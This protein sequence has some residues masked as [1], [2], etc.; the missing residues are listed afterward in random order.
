VPE[1]SRSPAGPLFFVENLNA[2]TLLIRILTLFLALFLT[3]L[4]EEAPVVNFSPAQDVC[5]E[6]VDDV[7]EEAI[8]QVVP[9]SH[10]KIQICSNPLWA[11]FDQPLW[12]G[13]SCHPIHFSF[14]RKW[15]ISCRLRL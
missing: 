9:R 14:E 8:V 7:E 2:S 4:P 6:N 1:K 15:L 11:G 13:D 3:L 5:V 10:H 12:Q